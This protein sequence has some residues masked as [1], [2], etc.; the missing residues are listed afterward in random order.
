MSGLPSKYAKMGFSKGWKAFRSSTKKVVSR[1]SNM[2]RRKISRRYARPVA[3]MSRRRKSSGSN[4]NV[5]S[6]VL[7]PAFVYGAIRPKAKELAQPLTSMLPLGNNSDEVAFGLLGY[8][9][10]KKGSGMVKNLGS[11][12]LTVEAASLGN[13][14]VAPM[15]GGIT[16]TAGASSNANSGGWV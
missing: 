5:L 3:R 10:H 1:G 4:A 16:T 15:V 8:F 11:A 7:L 6:G 9:M 12:I 13:N 14:I 2:A